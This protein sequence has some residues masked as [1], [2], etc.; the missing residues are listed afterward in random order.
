MKA[1]EINMTPII[2]FHKN[3]KFGLVDENKNFLI[4]CKYSKILKPFRFNQGWLCFTIDDDGLYGW[5]YYENSQLIEIKPQYVEVDYVSQEL[6]GVQSNDGLW[7][8]VNPS[9]QQIIAMQYQKIRPFQCHKAVVSIARKN[10]SPVWGVIDLL[11][12]WVVP[13]KYQFIG[14]ENSGLRCFK[15]HVATQ[16]NLFGF[17]ADENGQEVI[18]AEFLNVSNF[19]DEIAVVSVKKGNQQS[20]AVINSTGKVIAEQL[21][22]AQICA[23]GFS[24]IQRGKFLEFI[25]RN[26]ET[27]LKTKEANVHQQAF[28]EQDNLSLIGT[29]RRELIATQHKK[30]WGFYK[31]TAS[32]VQLHIPHVYEELS[33]SS[34]Q[35]QRCAVVIN[36][37]ATYIDEDGN[38]VAPLDCTDVL[39]DYQGELCTLVKYNT[40]K[41]YAFMNKDGQSVIDFKYAMHFGDF[42]ESG[43]VYVLTDKNSTTD[44]GFIDQPGFEYWQH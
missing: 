13:A 31:I 10:L 34:F 21:K 17:L 7:G 35:H 41:P 25:D 37:K 14:Q 42:D 3:Q 8:F 30:K 19:Y 16:G 12:N 28:Q 39:L 20:F 38:R 23:F 29:R 5:I 18:P 32:G 26:G 27:V 24:L 36:G 43:L 33:D 44:S 11:G 40:E 4:E 6:I 9:N 2:P 1:D 15:I 22:Q